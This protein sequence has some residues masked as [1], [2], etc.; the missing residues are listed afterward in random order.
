MFK[1][2]ELGWKEISVLALIAYVFSFAIRMIWVQWAVTHPEFFWNGQLMINTNDGYFFASAVDYLLTG[3]HAD[4]PRISVALNS[5]PG[6]IYATYYLVKLTPLSLE[7]AILYMPSIIA[8]FV[9]IPII[10]TGKLIKLPW[11]GFFAALL[12]SITWSYYNRTMV[13]YYDTDMFSVFLQFTIFYFFL[14]TIYSK[15]GKNILWLTAALLIYPCFYPQGLSLIYAMFILWVL[16]QLIFQKDQQ[17]SYLFIIVTSIAL[18]A[19]PAWIKIVLIVGIFIFLEYI[20]S[21]LNYKNFFYLALASLFV[22]FFFGDTFGLIMEKVKA[23][24][25]RGIEAGDLHFYEVMQTVREAGKIS[26]DTVANRITGGPIL[27]ILSLI[28]YIILVIKHK[29]FII[30][31][32]LI[33]V[34]IFAHWAGLR[35]TVYAVPIAA[36]SII[37]LFYFVSRYIVNEKIGNVLFVVTSLSTLYPN[38]KHIIY[39]KVPTVMNKMEVQDLDKLNKIAASKDYTIAWWD[40]GY[41]IWFYSDTSTLIDGGKHHEDNYIVSKIL[42]SDSSVLAANLSRLAVEMFV[43]HPNATVAKI[44][45]NK[46]NPNTLLQKLEKNKY[47]LLQKTREIYLYLPFRMINIFPTVMLFGNIDLTTGKRLYQPTFFMTKPV[48]QE[49]NIIRLSNGLRL[50]IQNG[51]LLQGNKKYPVTRLVV[52]TLQKDMSIKTMEQTYGKKG[53]LSVIYLQSYGRVVLLDNRTFNSLYIQMFMLGHYDKTL[54]E[55]VVL[56]PYTR[57]YRIKK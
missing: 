12:G 21:K 17:N 30:A 32:P 55:P 45:F 9:V 6:M 15:E 49:G 28:G 50:D 35:F 54:F 3:A 18:W 34:G 16:Y 20:K 24:L 1:N 22:F 44:L 31:L 4:N 33:G 48:R 11:V 26:W 13:G 39:Y 37:Y 36:F 53:N 8:S 38:I 40:Y 47:A 57:I 42:Q 52:S 7:T 46:T 29:P 56:S 2:S 25:D 19:I 43:K 10:L 5:Y 41:P 14:L 23:Y 27:F 51:L